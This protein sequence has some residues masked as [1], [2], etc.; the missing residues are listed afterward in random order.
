[1][2]YDEKRLRAIFDKTRGLCHICWK[3]IA[4]SNYGVH[5]SRG[6]WHV[7]HS[8]PL[9]EGGTDH[10]NNLFPAH[11]SCNCSKQ[12]RSNRCA[13][14]VHGRTRAPMS[15]TAVERKKTENAFTGALSGALLG[16]RF[17]GPAGLWIGLIAGGLLAYAVDPEAS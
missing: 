3:P 16:A 7:D 13:R 11:T 1:M 15:A 9:A 5:G 10:L 12:A 2:A 4:F 14:Q 6:G 8:V 17:G